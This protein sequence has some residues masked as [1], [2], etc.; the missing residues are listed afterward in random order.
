MSVDLSVVVPAYNEEGRL[1]PTLDAICAH[2]R[3]EPGR[4]GD[5]EL[6]VVDD[7]STDAT[8]Q[9]AKEAAADEPRI[10]LVSGNGNR[11]KG[12]ALRLGVLASYGRR[13]LIT[14]ADLATPIEE[15]DRLDKQLAA[16]DSAA[17][18]GS[19]AHPDSHIEVH[20][21]PLRE[22]MGRMGNRLIRAVAVPGIH[23]TQCGFKLFDGDR[24]RA[25]FADS[26]LDGWGI[27]VEILRFF[28]RAGWPVTEV[29]VRWSHQ[30][31]SKVRP[32]D[33]GRVLLE[34]LR[35]R[36]RA[37]RRVDL[38]VVGLF[39][40]ASVLLYKNLWADLDRGY[41][42]DSGQ[43]Q[44][45][46]EWFFAVTADN[47]AHL[48]NPLFTTLQGFPDGVN[49]MAN[50]V[51]FGLSVPLAPVTLLFG[52]TVTWALVLT[53]GLAAT[54][55]AWYWLIARRLVT[56]RWAAAFGAAFAAFAPPMISHGN[57]H[58]NFLVLFMIPVIID[59]AL[60]LCEGRNVVRDGVLLGLFAT[61]QIFLGE[62]PLL[63]A[64]VGMLLFALSY[65]LARRDVAQAARRPLLRGLAVAAAVCLPLIAFPLGWQ[66]FGPQSYKSVLHGD[67][68]G[69]SPLAFLEFAGRSLAGSDEGADPLA[70]N[71]TEQNAFYGWPLI[72]LAV[73][74]VVRLW[75]LALVKA[76]AFTGLAAAFL[77]LGPKFRIPYTDTVLTGPWRALAHQP[78]FE[79]VIESRVALIC[80]PVLG[81]LIALAADRLVVTR[82]R[83]NQVVGL[84]AVAA[85]LLPVLPT[86][87]PVRERSQV[88]EFI[89][90]GMYRS[91]LGEGESVVTVPLPNPGSAE[92]LHWQSATGL[93][94]RV[95]GGYFNGPWGP[96]RIGIYGATPRHTSNLLNEVRNS[97][98]VP[99][100]GP[101]W[102]AQARSD[103]AAWKAG[104]VVLEPQYNDAALYAT[105][106][107]LLGRPGKRVGGVWVWDVRDPKDS[108]RT[109][110]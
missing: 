10:Q 61:Y 73:A 37:V 16:E 100:I 84:A 24:A 23:D 41:L 58:P 80:A 4:W 70:L 14:D 48:R 6:I 25:A 97:G 42:A 50:T 74:I 47:V 79:S 76:L 87:Y 69:N 103:L 5:W 98:R 92:A 3:A 34:L 12:S 95:A 1:R 27:D 105:V 101:N 57:A 88:P 9:I 29:P 44:N 94:F 40:L 104:L 89:T 91:Y 15:L 11:G 17:A 86:P 59:R 52:P 109:D 68:A 20:Q 63:L 102:Q 78:L 13:V 8:A 99:T 7:G 55:G 72:A 66:F 77:S 110:S 18:I 82:D 31:G 65:A 75:R 90:Q 107:K 22:W 28:R 21:R 49:L 43:D 96:D 46:W 106:E 108:V 60:R 93:G 36:A 64:V 85:A 45:Q 54:A 67:N 56:N 53:L 2:L 26:R 38:A 51:M 35:L 83:V 81:V 71:R 62:E 33:Y 32:L 39:V 19:R 30:E